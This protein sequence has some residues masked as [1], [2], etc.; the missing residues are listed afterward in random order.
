M[1]VTRRL[2]DQLGSA[3]REAAD[4]RARRPC[5]GDTASRRSSRPRPPTATP[6]Q[7]SRGRRSPASS[8]GA[9]SGSPSTRRPAP[10][11]LREAGTDRIARPLDSDLAEDDP[12]YRSVRSD[13]A[14]AARQATASFD[15][16]IT[17]P[18]GKVHRVW[19]PPLARNE[20]VRTPAR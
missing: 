10:S 5:S 15:V 2:R 19:T 17:A 4:R 16:V 6:G 7:P 14:A 3:A 12:R 13:L 11:P 9:T 8:T 18:G 1:K 20:P